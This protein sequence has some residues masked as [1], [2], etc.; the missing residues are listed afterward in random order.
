MKRRSQFRTAD[1]LWLITWAAAWIGSW[2]LIV[3]LFDKSS[4]ASA[5]PP[6]LRTL[7]GTIAVV[8]FSATP[9]VAIGAMSGN[10][11]RGLVIGG[12]VAAIALVLAMFAP[13]VPAERHGRSNN[14][15]STAYIPVAQLGHCVILTVSN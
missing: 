1:L 5:Y 2:A 4:P 8:A 6:W 13:V 14:P 10:L 3:Q 11:K 15:S 9:C 12:I 7:A